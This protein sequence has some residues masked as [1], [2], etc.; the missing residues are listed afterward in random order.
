MASALPERPGNHEAYRHKKVGPFPVLSVAGFFF[1]GPFFFQR[2]FWAKSH[3]S[4]REK[5]Q[6]KIDSGRAWEQIYKVI[7]DIG[8]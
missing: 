5:N 8:V 3:K 4:R 7:F 2:L 1:R 6:L